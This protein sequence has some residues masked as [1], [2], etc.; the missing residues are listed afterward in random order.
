MLD[1]PSQAHYPPELDAEGDLGVLADEDKAAVRRLFKLL[2]GV[3]TDIAP[4]MQ[5][6]VIDHVDIREAWFE[7]AVAERWRGGRKLVPDAWVES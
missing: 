3:A 7:H 1:Q 2:H 5:I 6:I 4:K